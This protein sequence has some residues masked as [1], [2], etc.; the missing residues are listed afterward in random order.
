MMHNSGMKNTNSPLS[1]KRVIVIGGGSGI[2]LAVAR[3]AQEA[4]VESVLIAGRSPERLETAQK[5]LGGL[6]RTAV[7]DVAD[8][9]AVAQF[10]SEASLVDHVA[11]TAGTFAFAPLLETPL[12]EMRASVEEHLWG[13]V[14]VARHAAPKMRRGGSITLTSGVLGSR[15]VPGSAIGTAWSGAV[16]G[17]ARAL[18]VEFAPLGL[19]A[20]AVAPGFI[21]TPLVR[22]LLGDGFAEAAKGIGAAYPVGRIGTADEAAQAVLFLMQNG[23]VTGEVLH[24]D[25]GGRLA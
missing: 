16:E 2:G 23:Y 9:A 13:A 12:A 21:E 8:E 11:V 17:L 6:A 22:G 7:M 25:G 19:R 3:L 18:A 4:D 15:P 10:F 5:T 24:V 14:Y 20:N 1:G